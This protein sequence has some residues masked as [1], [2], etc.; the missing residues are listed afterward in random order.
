[1]TE[2]DLHQN[3][4]DISSNS[5]SIHRCYKDYCSSNEGPNTFQANLPFSYDLCKEMVYDVY[6]QYREGVLNVWVND[7]HIITSNENL[8]DKFDGFAYFGFSGYL[9]GF[10]RA[11]I[12]SPESYWCND[13]INDIYF[14]SK[15]NDMIIYNNR[16]PS[17]IPAGAPIQIIAK[18]KDI[19]G[20]FIPHL[21]GK[22]VTSWKLT[23]GYDC[24]LS[25]FNWKSFIYIDNIQIQNFVRLNSIFNSYLN[26]CLLLFSFNNLIRKLLF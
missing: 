18:F 5:L 24:G 15:F 9:R 11:M 6:M 3:Q 22:S 7:L 17:N 12:I 26:C 23:I 14:D 2:I 4:G 19:E 16:L 1:M 13:Q 10:Q 8:L 25:V 21:Y 20:L